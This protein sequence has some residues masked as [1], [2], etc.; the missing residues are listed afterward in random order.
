[1]KT[2]HILMIVGII[3]VIFI[4]LKPKITFEGF[5]QQNLFEYC[6]TKVGDEGYCAS[7]CGPSASSCYDQ[8]M[9]KSDGSAEAKLACSAQCLRPDPQFQP[10]PRFQ[11]T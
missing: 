3:V 11:Y 4:L 5:Q 8:C 7:I 1:M 10:D 6:L 2:E 9:T